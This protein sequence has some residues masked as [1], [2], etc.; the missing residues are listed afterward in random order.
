M[1]SLY[2]CEKAANFTIGFEKKRKLHPVKMDTFISSQYIVA[3][4]AT[5]IVCAFWMMGG[6]GD[7]A[8]TN[9]VLHFKSII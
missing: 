7:N 2:C 4:E 5:E 3:R 8:G 6:T 1:K 9:G